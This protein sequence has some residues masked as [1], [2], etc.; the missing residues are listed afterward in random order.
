MLFH[1]VDFLCAKNKKTGGKKSSPV[2][3]MASY[4]FLYESLHVVSVPDQD[5]ISITLPVLIN[6]DSCSLVSRLVWS[7]SERLVRSN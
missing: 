4:L 6:P 3:L 5:L 7:V 2:I 1:S